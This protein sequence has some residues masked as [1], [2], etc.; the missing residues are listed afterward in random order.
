MI[1]TRIGILLVTSVLLAGCA[2]VP[3]DQQFRNQP[4]MAV[5]PDKALVYFYRENISGGCALYVHIADG[6]EEIGELKNGAYLALYLDPGLHKFTPSV[7]SVDPA[8]AKGVDTDL[9]VGQIFFIKAQRVP[10]S[11]WPAPLVVG[12]SLQN[13][14][15][16]LALGEMANLANTDAGIGVLGRCAGIYL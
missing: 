9:K 5:K 6:S 4:P 15:S 10:L 16:E 8:N 14:P 2:S 1:A 12:E 7:G 3:A 11:A 13:V